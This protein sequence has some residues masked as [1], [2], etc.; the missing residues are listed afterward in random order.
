MRGT[1]RPGVAWRTSRAPALAAE[2]PQ[3]RARL[4]RDLGAQV[5][6]EHRGNLLECMLTKIRF[7]TAKVQEE[8]ATAA[9][10]ATASQQGTAGASGAGA[11]RSPG[12]SGGPG[13]SSPM[14]SSQAVAGSRSEYE[15]QVRAQAFLWVLGYAHACL[16]TCARARASD[17]DCMRREGA[18]NIFHCMCMMALC[19]SNDVSR[20]AFANPE[21]RP[22]RDHYYQG[23]Y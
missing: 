6:D 20:M 8:R 9:A 11:A 1:F 12:S 15:Q 7:K 4:D 18:C 22:E 21:G 16:C 3:P 17:C 2:R 19:V 10:A 23:R 5:G 13:L 14:L